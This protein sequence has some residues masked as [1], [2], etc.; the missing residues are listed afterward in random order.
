MAV[1]GY[2][3]FPTINAD[4]VVFVSEDDLWTVPV[5]GGVARRLT[6]NRAETS[7]PRLSPDGALVAFTSREED[8]PEVWCMPAAGGPARRLT[9]L[10]GTI[11]NGVGWSADGRVAAVSTA[12]QPFRRW[13]MPMLVDP[14]TGDIEGLPLGPARELSWAPDGGGAVLGRYAVDPAR[15]KRYRGGTAGQL[16]V[17]RAGEGTFRRILADVDADLAHPLWVGNRIYFIS[18]HE[19]VGNLYS[20]R[21]TGADLRR[22]TDHAD[23]YARFPPTDGARIV[24]QHAGDIW[25]L[26]PADDTTRRIDIDTAS[27]RV[28]RNRR[29]V[30]AAD[31][32]T[33]FAAHPDGR[34][35]VIETRGQLFDLP[36]WEGAARP[37]G[38]G[39]G[40]RQRLAA[41]LPDGERLLVVS[42]EGGEE[43][44]VLHAPDGLRAVAEGVDLGDLKHVAVAPGG[45]ARAAVINQR[46]EL[47]LVGLDSGDA[48]RLDAS[49]SGELTGAAWA[50]DGR[51]LA[52]SCAL[53]RTTRSI[54]LVD[55]DSGAIVNVTRPEFRD[56][57]PAWDPA[58]RYLYFL[59]ARIFDPVP[60]EH[61]I[62]L[63]F[64]RTVKPMVVPL[65]AGDRSPFRPQ[66]RPMKTESPSTP[67]GM[68]D[69]AVDTDLIDR[70]VVE[71][72][73]E[74]GRYLAVAPLREA[75]LLLSAQVEGST[76]DFWGEQPPKNSVEKVE[77]PTGKKSTLAGGVNEFR[78]SLD[79]STLVYRA[80]DRLRAIEGGGKP[81]RP[82]PGSST[83][84][85]PGS[86]RS[87][88]AA[89]RP[90]RP[91]P[92]ATRTSPDE[93]PAGW[94][95][96]GRAS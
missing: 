46:N 41:W 2:L 95:W 31:F 57:A 94:T 43:H 66:P 1:T 67:P 55:A 90:S 70:R 80:G 59:S 50:P 37:V 23:Y 65:R 62:D 14:A 77:I 3:R 73:V 30:P 15:W 54:R 53:T 64:P 49:T 81:P 74:V 10:G 84:P 88:P 6:A 28:Q 36:L 4:T 61:F 96:G 92:V 12:E 58:G 24:Y 82:A 7:R 9:H 38:P 47:W 42:D 17:D 93:P 78:V 8:H 83:G 51:W 27:P 19:G 16:W 21:P 13:A 72:P 89:G 60:D 35:V 18:D 33:D 87:G 86:A 56:F 25:L 39:S 11:T 71:L 75:I 45:A 26:D 76:D 48:R 40:V 85:G 79:G 44:L 68:V 69:V 5:Q 34:S 63:N 29:F 91:P 32:L 52:Y 20:V 22:H